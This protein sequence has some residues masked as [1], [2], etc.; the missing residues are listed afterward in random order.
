M[1]D[2]KR[3]HPT[4]SHRP[5]QSHRSNTPKH[6]RQKNQTQTQLE[7]ITDTPGSNQ[8]KQRITI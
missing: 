8:M 4:I 6:Q 1:I 5:Y 2:I 7:T 3:D